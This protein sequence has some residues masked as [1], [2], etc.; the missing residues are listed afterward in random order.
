MSENFDPKINNDLDN[1]ITDEMA[2]QLNM[3]RDTYILIQTKIELFMIKL[4]ENKKDTNIDDVK[5]IE[6]FINIVSTIIIKNI[7]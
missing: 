2:I 7:K 4:N 6:T 5:L 1:L 3:V